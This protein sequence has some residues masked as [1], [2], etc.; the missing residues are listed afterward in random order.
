MHRLHRPTPLGRLPIASGAL[1]G[2]PSLDTATPTCHPPPEFALRH[3]H[4]EQHILTGHRIPQ[5]PPAAVERFDNVVKFCTKPD[6]SEASTVPSPP[7]DRPSAGRVPARD[8][9]HATACHVVATVPTR[10]AA[11]V[12]RN[13]RLSIPLMGVTPLRLSR[14]DPVQLPI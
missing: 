10:T 8:A 2:S 1:P 3:A 13:K 12:F 11:Y 14:S 4:I 9:V 7:T 5:S 6:S